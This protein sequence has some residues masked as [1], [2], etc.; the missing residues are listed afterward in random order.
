MYVYIYINKTFIYKQH[1]HLYIYIYK[2]FHIIEINNIET[3]PNRQNIYN[4]M[5]LQYFG[6]P[7]N[8][9]TTNPKVVTTFI[10]K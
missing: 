5:L 6:T 3:K 7:N 1:P 10:N 8:R 9:K 2:Q 4:H